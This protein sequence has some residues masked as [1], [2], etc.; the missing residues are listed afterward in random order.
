MRTNNYDSF[1]DY[2]QN[3][4]VSLYKST[5]KLVSESN[6][7]S[8]SDTNSNNTSNGGTNITDYYQAIT[9]GVID[10]TKP[11]GEYIV[12]SLYDTSGKVF[13]SNTK[14]TSSIYSLDNCNLTFSNIINGTT[15]DNKKIY[16]IGIINNASSFQK[17]GNSIVISSNKKDINPKEWIAFKNIDDK[18]IDILD[19]NPNNQIKT[20]KNKEIK[21]YK[22]KIV[23]IHDLRSILE[24][25]GYFSKIAQRVASDESKA[26]TFTGY[27]TRNSF[28]VRSNSS[29]NKAADWFVKEVK[30]KVEA[31]NNAN[32]ANQQNESEINEKTAEELRSGL[33]NTGVAHDNVPQN[34]N[35]KPL[36]YIVPPIKD[37]SGMIERAR[38]SGYKSVLVKWDKLKLN[39]ANKAV[40]NMSGHNEIAC[41]G[42]LM[43][44]IF[45][46][47]DGTPAFINIFPFTRSDGMFIG[48]LPKNAST[49]D[50]IE[51]LMSKNLYIKYDG[52]F[53]N[54]MVMLAKKIKE[55]WVAI[56]PLTNRTEPIKV[57]N[58]SI[59]PN[60]KPT[61]QNSNSSSSQINPELQN[62][63]NNLKGI[64]DGT[65][66]LKLQL[67][68]G[69][70]IYK[71]YLDI[72]DN[73]TNKW[74]IT[75]GALK[76]V[77]NGLMD[78]AN[79]F[80]SMWS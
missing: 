28:I 71:N 13:S 49:I 66:E 38:F 24:G 60:Q 17:D 53:D 6:G 74:A 4:N 21:E 36:T 44:L 31:F 57:L 35:R 11:T 78:A 67:S 64:Y 80:I 12:L 51:T 55:E 42:D 25:E 73:A 77:A 5:V 69:N 16:G 29:I 22:N 30:A 8:N 20:S 3:S 15:L 37:A 50:S 47:E 56:V 26:D 14:P 68:P 76:T 34:I 62:R 43:L 32:T 52:T 19:G 63:L 61:N 10:T 54:M 1:L 79:S 48:I 58:T 41:V 23:D 59:A 2:V 40:S 72:V 39:L 45:R 65:K 75:K 27:I 7:T 46:D 18:V 70:K 9:F 33:Q